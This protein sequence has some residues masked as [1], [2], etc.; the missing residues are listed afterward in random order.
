MLVNRSY[1]LDIIKIY[2]GFVSTP[3][4][5]PAG[6]LT[7]GYGTN[8]EVGISKA[9]AECLLLS[10]LDEIESELSKLDWYLSLSEVRK[11]VIIDMC[12]QLGFAGMLAFKKMI[13]AIQK[14][15]FDGASKEMLDSRWALQTPLRA[16]QNAIAMK[17]NQFF[18]KRV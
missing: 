14:E 6:F 7:I 8:I 9:Q 10:K 12:Y 3:Y 4:K 18:E 16:S 5:C 1:M 17:N 15:D 2:E 11:M 13:F